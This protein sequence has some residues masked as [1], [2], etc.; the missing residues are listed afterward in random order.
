MRMLACARGLSN[1]SVF[2]ETEKATFDFLSYFRNNQW[3]IDYC[4]TPHPAQKV[5]IFEKQEVFQKMIIDFFREHLFPK[6]IS[7]VIDGAYGNILKEFCKEYKYFIVYRNKFEM[8][9]DYPVDRHQ[10]VLKR[11]K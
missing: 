3:K 10:F 1:F 2:Y 8:T 7:L 6:N 9:V 4:Y 5:S 11:K